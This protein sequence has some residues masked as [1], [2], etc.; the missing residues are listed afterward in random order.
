MKGVE[1]DIDF[2]GL[3]LQAVKMNKLKLQEYLIRQETQIKKI[4]HLLDCF[5]FKQALAIAVESGDPNEISRVLI[6]LV[7]T[8]KDFAAVIEI[9]FSVTNGLRHLR[10]FAKKRHNLDQ[11]RAISDFIS[12]R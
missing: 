9:A 10:N 7:K 1:L 4:P 8:H 2:G 3:A 12:R 6:N 5:E 11:L